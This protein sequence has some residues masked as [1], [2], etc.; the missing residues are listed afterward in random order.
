[1][2][3]E[4]YNAPSTFTIFNLV[5]HDKLN[6]FIIIYIDDILVYSNLMFEELN[7]KNSMILML[8]YSNLPKSFEIHIDAIGFV[9]RGVLMPNGHV[10]TFESK[11]LVKAPLKINNS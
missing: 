4:L 3:F 5:F 6:E 11:K 8:K 1:M 7:G 10:I 9:I 2:P